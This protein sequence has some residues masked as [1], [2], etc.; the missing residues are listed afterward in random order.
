MPHPAMEPEDA[1]TELHAERIDAVAR[2]L[3]ACGA[4]SVLDLG[5]GPGWL[6]ARLLVEPAI[7]RLVGIDTSA[8]ALR[9]AERRISEAEVTGDAARGRVTLR[10]GS[11]MELGTEES[12][13]DAAAMVE[14]IEHVEPSQ[15]SR[16][17]RSIF[18]AARPRLVLITTPNREYNVLYGLADDERRHPE[19][20]FEWSRAKFREWALGVG[21][22][23]GYAV[24]MADVGRSDP[25]RGAPTQMA[26]F[27]MG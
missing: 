14:T 3:L 12:G 7:V 10:N 22:R 2:R 13:F 5:C 25:L 17:E 24:E 9:V 11:F 1:N 26:V 27:T 20:R 23:R 19:H 18:E 16:L 4:R 21:G 15:L 8:A 6:L